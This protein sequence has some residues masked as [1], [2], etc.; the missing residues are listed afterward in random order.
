MRRIFRII[1]PVSLFLGIVLFLIYPAIIDLFSS[2]IDSQPQVERAA[3][4]P[5]VAS[6]QSTPTQVAIRTETPA[7][8]AQKPQ[9]TPT[10]V[11]QVSIDVN[12]MFAP[13]PNAT[14]N[15]VLTSFDFLTDYLTNS[16]YVNLIDGKPWIN[17]SI[18]VEQLAQPLSGVTYWDFW[19]EPENWDSPSYMY[20]DDDGKWTPYQTVMIRDTTGRDVKAYLLADRKGPGVMDRIWFTE[21]AM[22][23][24][25]TAES[26]KN[27]GPIDDMNLFAEWGNLDKLGMLRIEVDDQ[28]VYDGPIVDWFSGKALKLTPELTQILTWRHREYGS[29]GS[30]VPVPYQ[31]HLRVL[32]YG[33]S[34]KPKWFMAT[35]VRLPDSVRV[36]P[37]ALSE[38]P[39]AE[40]TRLGLNVLRPENFI[41]TFPGQRQFDLQSTPANPAMIRLNGAGT[42]DAI[43]ILVSKK[44]DT[45]QL[46]IRVRYENQTGIYMPLVAFCGD[47]KQLVL[48][49]STPLGIV[50]STDNF[51][52]YSNLPMPFQNG[53]TI[54]LETKSAN[55][56]P[57]TLRLAVSRDG[58]NTQ[59]WVQY[60]ELE[61][62]AVYGPDYHAQIA[63]NGKLVG[64][65]LATEEQD[66]DKIPKIFDIKNPNAEDLV[67]RAWAMGYLEGNLHLVDGTGREQIFGG[68]EDW[69]DGGFYFNRGYTNPAGGS[70]R[71]FGG[72]LRYKDGKDGYATI[73]R[74]FNDLSAFRFQNGL[75]MNLGHG[76]WGNNFPV[77]FGTTAYYYKEIR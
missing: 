69:A 51:I 9:A 48:H 62:L 72:I 60:R 39:I 3:D 70:N 41:D 73:F 35:G 43:Q 12:P 54:E 49:R 77:K 30:I 36:K 22:W 64:L 20:K 66:L 27:V 42:V 8:V 59:L 52:F 44:I 18:N 1:F 10:L 33:G 2:A 34:K 24:L 40:M 4:L 68:H 45:K 63:G 55:S 38:L 14:R 61:K 23:M 5:T 32:L 28:A 58:A 15:S 21:D 53:M 46:W 25:E 76:T 13:F 74:Y 26:R 67:K 75:H 47:P 7:L 56:I 71:P 29:N 37:F 16:T 31:K 6:I 19:S 11:S 57:V 65:V 17:N 50:E